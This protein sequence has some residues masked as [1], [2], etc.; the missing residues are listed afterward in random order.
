MVRNNIKLSTLILCAAFIIAGCKPNDSIRFDGCSYAI[1]GAD[2]SDVMA[3]LEATIESLVLPE[4]RVY[5]PRSKLACD[6]A[7][8]S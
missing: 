5:I 4:E 3:N 2:S 8:L 7:G 1:L 6:N